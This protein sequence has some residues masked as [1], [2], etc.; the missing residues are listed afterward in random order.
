MIKIYAD[1][2]LI[3]DSRLREPGKDYTLLGLRTTTALNKGGTAEIVMPPGHPAYSALTGHRTIVE[4]YRDD[5]LRFRG[6]ALGYADVWTNQRTWT[7]EGELCFFQDAVSRPYLYQD[8]PEAIFAAV[9]E[10]YN[11]QVDAFKQ[12]KVG[13]VTVTDDND[14]VRLE[15]ETAEQ[16]LDTLNKLQTR[17]GGYFRFSTDEDGARVINWYAQLNNRSG[18]VIE[19]G[20]NLLDFA[21]NGSNPDLLTGVVPYGAKDEETGARVDITSVNDG[22]DYIVDATAVALRG[23]ILKPVIWDDV[24][25]PDNLLIKAEAHLR[26][27]RQVVTSLQL[28]AVDLARLNTSI[29]SFQDGDIVRVL[30]KPHAVDEDFQLVEHTDDWLVADASTITLGKDILSLTDADVAG[31]KQ[32]QSDLHRVQQSIKADYKLNTADQISASEYRMQSLITQT[33]EGINAEVSSIKAT[34]DGAAEQIVELETKVAASMT[35]E[36]VNLAI[37]TEMGKGAS[38]VSTETGYT[39][40]NEGLTVEKSNS[41]MKTQITEDGMTVYKNGEE[42]LRANNQGVVATD[43]RARTYLIVGNNSRFEDMPEGNRTGCFWIGE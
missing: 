5:V 3:Y 41:E 32:S 10:D 37:S 20:E 31:D 12:F 15:S 22:K 29:D 16:V 33:A 38:K 19:F 26:E 6:R 9:V 39:F 7:C 17:C 13:T 23:T 40:D 4:M 2:K 34:A 42:V 28:T 25:Q 18:Q 30:S 24:T 21:R 14:Y 8:T 43:L 1:G 35:S 36:Q 27:H 11:S